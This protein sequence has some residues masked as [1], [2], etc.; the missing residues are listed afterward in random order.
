MV[1]L[2][3][4]W[5]SMICTFWIGMP[6]ASAC[7]AVVC[8]NMCGVTGTDSLS[9]T[10]LAMFLTIN[11]RPLLVMALCGAC[12]VTIRAS[13]SSFRVLMYRLSDTTAF[14]LR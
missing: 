7:V 12:V 11:Y 1:V 10:L 3:L 2:I 13:L 4:L 8:L 14:A 6:F 9:L 5:P